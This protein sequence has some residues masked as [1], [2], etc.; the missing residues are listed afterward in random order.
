MARV[1]EAEPEG[2]LAPVRE[3][4]DERIVGAHDERRIG[5]EL[6]GRGAPALGDVLELAVPVE[7]V[8]EEVRQAD[9]AW[10][11]AAHDLRQRELVD[12]EQAEL[13]AVGCEEGGGDARGEVGTRAVPRQPAGR[14]EDRA[15]HGRRRG[16][17]V[18][19]RDERKAGRQ[20]GS[21]RV[22]RIGVELPDE[23]AGQRGAAATP[24]GAREPADEPGRRGLERESGGHPGE[25]TDRGS[26]CRA[27]R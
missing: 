6:S 27:C 2:L 5:C 24:R 10:L 23:L 25:R 12:L 17:A 16:L 21:K 11:R 8:P 13:C 18:R 7:L 1:V 3:R 15:R 9:H 14:G 26:L 4:R 22:E 20:P 19:R